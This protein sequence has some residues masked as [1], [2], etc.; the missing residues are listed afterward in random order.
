MYYH[1]TERSMQVGQRM[2]SSARQIFAPLAHDVADSSLTLH[3][4]PRS[5]PDGQAG[6]LE[7]FSW[8]GQRQFYPA[9]VVKVAYLAAAQA[10]LREGRIT[11][12]SE[13][14]RA[15]TDMILWSSNN[16]TN[17]VIDLLTG[18]TGDTLLPQPQMAQWIAQR[19]SVN[20]FFGELGW[21]EAQGVNICQK[22]MDDD[23]YGR[24]KRFVT[25]DGK[26]N[27]NCLSSDFVARLL[28]EICTG[29]FLDDATSHEA[30]QL[31]KRSLASDFK[32][33]PHAQVNGFLAER[34]PENL[35]YYSKA[36]WNGWT[37]DALSSYNRHDSAHFLLPQAQC[38][39]YGAI[40]IVVFSHGKAVSE[41]IT[42]LPQIGEALLQI[43]AQY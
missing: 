31:L 26:N 5:G 27:H 13:L 33:L 18:T 11:A 9:S 28:S 12:H 43:L 3:L 16:A 42:F 36:G 41:D 14:N 7:G 32:S 2:L 24:E 20:R 23:R 10:A 6:I 39:A 38:N 22:L 35:Q 34:F 15:I 17:Y 4:F 19:E 30:A 40:T 29:K 25:R 21:P 37:G 8:Q 1:Q